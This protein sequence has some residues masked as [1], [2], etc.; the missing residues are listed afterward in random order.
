MTYAYMCIQMNRAVIVMR[1]EDRRGDISLCPH[2]RPVLAALYLYILNKSAWFYVYRL[3]NLLNTIVVF[4]L[5]LFSLF[6]CSWCNVSSLLKRILI[7]LSIYHGNTQSFE[8]YRSAYSFSSHYRL[9]RYPNMCMALMQVLPVSA[10]M[11]DTQR[12]TVSP[13][14]SCHEPSIL[15][16]SS[17]LSLSILFL[18]CALCFKP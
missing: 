4:R 6:L 9:F 12:M 13:Y 18:F 2:L 3:R 14:V 8:A 10:L 15:L 7:W 16:L 1:E 11:A 17:P 5:S